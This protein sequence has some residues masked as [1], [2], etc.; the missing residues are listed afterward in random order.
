MKTKNEIEQ[1]MYILHGDIQGVLKVLAG[2][3]RSERFI[4]TL[5]AM[6][7]EYRELAEA[8]KAAES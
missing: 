3:P 4:S 5:N 1:E 7:Q 2:N 8:Y 6:S